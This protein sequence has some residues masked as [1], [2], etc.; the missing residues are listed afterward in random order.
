MIL[1]LC[2]WTLF[3]FEKTTIFFFPSVYFRSSLLKLLLQFPEPNVVM[4]ISI[5]GGGG[6][7][8][9]YLKGTVS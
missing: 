5:R 1:F 6:S 7:I 9:L 2:D 8:L 3:I 4:L